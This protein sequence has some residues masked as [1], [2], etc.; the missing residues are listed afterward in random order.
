[1]TT[2]R[3]E[4]DDSGA[5]ASRALETLRDVNEHLVLAVV[6][7]QR[8]LEEARRALLRRERSAEHQMDTARTQGHADNHLALLAA[9]E[10][11]VLA[12]LTAQNLQAEAEQAQRRQTEFMAILAHELR[13]PLAPMRNVSALLERLTV[14]DPMLPRLKAIIERQVDHMAL[15]VDDLLDVSR[16]ITG[17]LRLNLEVV[18]MGALVQEAVLASQTGIDLRH[19]A[20][21]LEVPSHDVMVLGDHHRL[22][23]V[24]SNLLDNASKY[25]P[26]GGAISLTLTTDAHD[27]TLTVVDSGIGITAA[28]LPGVFGL[29]AQD[30]H[31]V[32]YNGVGLGIG[33]TE[34]HELVLA[35]GGTV[36]AHSRGATQGSQF[37]VTLP[38]LP[39]VPTDLPIA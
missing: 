7:A 22:V 26:T 8:Q 3:E 32:G 30:V 14:D 36:T 16:A 19:Q 31:A 17:K 29:F 4:R 13:T 6:E 2:V 11:L 24:I 38:L 5:P 10:K 34:V 15:L 9:N 37:V 28:A 12:A 33:L 27:V 25:T 23:Q 39:P 20:F 18:T 21:K 35:H 1:M